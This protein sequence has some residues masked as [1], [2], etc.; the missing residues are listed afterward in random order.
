MIDECFALL[1][2]MDALGDGKILGE[3]GIAD[4]TNSGPLF[5]MGIP[6]TALLKALFQKAPRGGPY[7]PHPHRQRDVH[8]IVILLVIKI[9]FLVLTT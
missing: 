5:P 2:E 8:I 6:M 1:P 3:R 7:F 4:Q 9:F